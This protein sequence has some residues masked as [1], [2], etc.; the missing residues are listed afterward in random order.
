MRTFRK[1]AETNV[2]DKEKR[3][4]SYLDMILVLYEEEL[5]GQENIH[6]SV[7]LFF[8]KESAKTPGHPSIRLSFL[9]NVEMNGDDE[10]RSKRFNCGF[11]IAWRWW[12]R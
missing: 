5:A 4:C 10:R 3:H 9:E 2:Y 6:F 8:F 12:R 7:K 1:I 11:Y